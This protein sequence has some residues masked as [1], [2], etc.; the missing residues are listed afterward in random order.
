[1][2]N[3][4]LYIPIIALLSLSACKKSFLD[5]EDVTSATEQNFYKTQSDAFKALVGVYDGLQRAGSSGFGLSVVATEVMSDNAFGATG[6]ADGF[7]FQM[8][9][10]FDKLR[11]PSDQDMFADN[12]SVY[13]KAIYR[14]NML[15]KILTRWIGK[16]TMICV[17]YMNRKQG[18]YVPTCILIW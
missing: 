4:K 15:L 18:L 12:W 6:N 16:A 9:D 11:S 7:G 2:K 3:L 8:I 13:Y 14:A 1:M 17:R 5:T 10:E